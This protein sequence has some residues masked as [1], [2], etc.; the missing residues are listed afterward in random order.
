MQLGLLA[1]VAEQRG[2]L[3]VLPS[4]LWVGL[5]HM[6]LPLLYSPGSR[7]S[8]RAVDTRPPNRTQNKTESNAERL[9]C[10]SDP[11]PSRKVKYGRNFP[12]CDSP[13]CKGRVGALS[14]PGWGDMSDKLKR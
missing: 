6:A 1:I 13:A 11:D 2:V 10:L 3:S 4:P 8:L 9:S 12:I 14:A 7:A 5:S